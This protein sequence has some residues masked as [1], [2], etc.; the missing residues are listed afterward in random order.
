MNTKDSSPVLSIASS[1]DSSKL[2]D[3]RYQVAQ[4]ARQLVSLDRK[5]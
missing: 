3:E 5:Y 1:D 4:D 2:G